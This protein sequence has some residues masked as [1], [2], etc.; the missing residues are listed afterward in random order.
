MFFKKKDPKTVNEIDQLIEA[1]FKDGSKV[2]DL[3]IKLLTSELFILTDNG[4]REEGPRDLAAGSKIGVMSYAMKDGTPFIPVFTSQEE[5][6]RSAPPDAGFTALQGHPIFMMAQ[7]TD[8]VI[9][10]SSKNPI[11]LRPDDIMQILGTFAAMNET[12]G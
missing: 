6:V 10:P 4:D 2:G 5:M 7:N 11:H 8:I 1:A 12:S 9:N 3:Y